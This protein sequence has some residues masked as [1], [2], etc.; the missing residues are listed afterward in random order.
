MDLIFLIFKKILL[1]SKNIWFISLIFSFGLS[2]NI[3]LSYEIATPSYDTLTLQGLI[4]II[5]GAMI[6]DNLSIK[7]IILLFLNRFGGVDYLN[8]QTYQQFVLVYFYFFIFQI[9]VNIIY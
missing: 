3:F 4:V 5:I 6:I 1:N 9:W 2:I 7:K 8:E